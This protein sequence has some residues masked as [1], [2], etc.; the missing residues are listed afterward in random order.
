M[1][2]SSTRLALRCVF[3]VVANCAA[4][5]G[6]AMFTFLDEERGVEVAEASLPS[7]LTR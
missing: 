2:E 3:V 7:R 1:T 5:T 6:N 4:A